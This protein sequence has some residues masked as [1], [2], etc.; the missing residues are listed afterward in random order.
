[1]NEPIP[2]GTT[3]NYTIAP[4]TAAGHHS[5]GNGSVTIPAN[6]TSA[7][8]DFTINPAGDTWH[9]DVTFNIN[10]TGYTFSPQPSPENPIDLVYEQN[11]PIT[12][13]MAGT[14]VEPP[15]APVFV[16][17]GRVI[18]HL[19]DFTSGPTIHPGNAN[20]IA[21][22]FDA[23]SGIS[24]EIVENY[25]GGSGDY[26]FRI[27]GNNIVTTD[28]YRANYDEGLTSIPLRVKAVRDALSCLE[29][30]GDITIAINPWNDNP[31]VVQEYIANVDE[32]GF[33]DMNVFEGRVSDADFPQ[34]AN[35]QR[36]IGLSTINVL[37]EAERGVST[38]M[39]SEITTALGARVT[40]YHGTPIRYDISHLD[41]IT[42]FTDEFYYFALD[43][44]EYRDH[45]NIPYETDVWVKTVKVTVYI[46]GNAPIATN[47]YYYDSNGD[48]VV[49]RLVVVFDKNVD[50][51]P[52]FVVTFGGT[53]LSVQNSSAS[54]D[55]VF[56]NL[57]GAPADL[58][59]GGML[60]TITSTFIDTN[61]NPQQ[62]VQNVDASDRAAP[63][64]LSATL[65]KRT[66]IT[67][68]DITVF[69]DV[70]V[71]T[72]SETVH[73][74]AT[75]NQNVPFRFAPGDIPT[76]PHNLNITFE[77]ASGSNNTYTFVVD[78]HY[79]GEGNGIQ[80]GDWIFIN[81]AA[82]EIVEDN[83]GN[84]QIIPENKR[85]PIEVNSDVEQ[86]HVLRI[87]SATYFDRSDPSDGYIDSINIDL[88]T[89]I[90]QVQAQRIAD[91]ITIA[92]SRGFTKGT[93]TLNQNGMGF[94]LTLVEHA[95]EMAAQGRRNE[96]LPRTSVSETDFVWLENPIVFGDTTIE[97]GL[98][99]IGDGV[100]P[101]IWHAVY[102]IEGDTT[103]DVMFSEDVFSQQ[104][105]IN[106]PYR[107]QTKNGQPFTMTF[108]N[109]GRPILRQNNVLRYGVESVSIAFPVSDDSI[110]I[111]A[112][113]YISDG[114]IGGNVQ[115]N[116]VFAPLILANT[117]PADLNLYVLP[118]PFVLAG[119]VPQEFE[120]ETGFRHH[121]ELW[122]KDRGLA[123]IVEAGGPVSDT[124]LQ[125]GS[126]T[127]FDQLGNAV[128]DR[129]EMDFIVLKQGD[130]QG[131]VAGTAVWDAKN[132]S[133]RTVGAG[134]YLAIVEIEIKFDDR[135]NSEIRTFRR[136]IAVSVGDR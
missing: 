14:Q 12:I 85:V 128:S 90:S 60:V 116:S 40:V 120:G 69:N 131:T 64:I 34:D 44:A 9:P 51:M 91:E 110:R 68:D 56:I 74:P 115:R 111:Y 123:F 112:G 72:F 53:Q 117:Y 130:R 80:N 113:G 65:N 30:T 16:P 63:V 13:K 83:W 10:F 78:S 35:R 39:I 57:S 38:G 127:I 84:P 114:E 88:G 126:V 96:F 59:S 58:T 17:D 86:K 8:I 87:V 76:Q 29:T 82:G 136:T 81:S 133:G 36:V 50:D 21:G 54:N 37:P 19:A 6:Q 89:L 119:S 42:A 46:S 47:A 66:L 61:D 121:Y 100:A 15:A 105:N 55:T 20:Q 134:A 132:R 93:V 94:G 79:S 124:S 18:E 77:S 101:V 1:L 52:E 92:P 43:T 71:V 49:D 11:V 106:E 108:K 2:V 125:R 62:V 48:G 67:N 27:D 104:N 22:S 23:V 4:G 33:V 75:A 109:N 25:N 95:A 73:I 118:Q 3:F 41:N 129:I 107:F 31:F 99:L 32:G 98:V 135:P 26:W 122:N 97:S 102:R 103:L 7:T 24:Y 70:L 5:L 28:A 45:N